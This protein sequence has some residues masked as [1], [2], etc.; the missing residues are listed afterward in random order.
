[1]NIF[2]RKSESR[3]ASCDIKLQVLM[4]AVLKVYDISIL[5]GHRTKE[6]QNSHYRSGTSKL[7]W[8][9][10]GHNDVPATS[11][12]ACPFPF[13]GWKNI[14]EFNKMGGIVKEKA[15]ELG[16]GIIWGGD[17]KNFY[18]GVHFQLVKEE[19]ELDV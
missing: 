9:D 2:S 3:L 7:K 8:P 13:C 10:S 14:D 1:M 18:D 5:C 11:I 12:D 4:R 19:E 16:I 6:V 17:W 15:K